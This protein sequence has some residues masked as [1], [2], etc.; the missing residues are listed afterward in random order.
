MVNLSFQSKHWAK[1]SVLMDKLS[2]ISMSV[3][4]ED[5]ILSFDIERGFR[6]LR[7]H[8]AMRDWFIFRYH[9]KYYQFVAFSFG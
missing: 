9:D 1:G 4:L 8:P 7:L 2:E 5:Q 3:Q 6:H